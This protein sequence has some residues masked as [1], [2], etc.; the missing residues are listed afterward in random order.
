MDQ[1]IDDFISDKR[2]LGRINSDRT[3][4]SYRG[5]LHVL[6]EVSG[7]RD[8]REIDREDVKRALRRWK[9]NT[10]RNAHSIF[11][12]FFDWMTEEAYRADNPAR[13]VSRPRKQPTSTYRMTRDEVIRAL[14]ASIYDRRA[15]R[16]AHFGFLAGLRRAELCG[17]RGAHLRRPGTIWLSADIAKGGKEAWLPVLPELAPVVEECRERV[18]DDEFVI[19]ARRPIDP[20]V[21]S[22]F[23]LLTRRATSPKAMWELARE[24]GNVAGL[25]HPLRP[26]LMRHAFGDHVAKTAGLRVAQALM[27]H[28]DVSTTAGTYTS[29][30]DL[31]ELRSAL[32]SFTYRGVE[33]PRFGGVPAV[34]PG[35]GAFG[36]VKATTGIEPVE[37][38][39]D[40]DQRVFERLAA[41]GREITRLTAELER[42]N[43]DRYPEEVR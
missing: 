28:S 25:D 43:R 17:L 34:I 39:S 15:F 14:D 29:E 4:V 13:M 11:L 6:Q 42:R 23:R 35:V 41:V 21:N 40:A 33:P 38:V 30:P 18:A 36:P 27:R 26:H 19:P 2:T 32:A 8:P 37:G 5:R 7:D 1:A 3:E 12:S 9:P 22:R 16:L 20:P 10:A 24:L 31:D